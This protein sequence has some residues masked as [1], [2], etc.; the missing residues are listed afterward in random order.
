MRHACGEARRL[1]RSVNR[2]ELL[3]VG[4]VSVLGLSVADLLALREAQAAST[5]YSTILL[6][7]TGGP[8]QFDTFDPK[9]EAPAEV[10]G[11]FKAIP[12]NV[13]GIQFA[14]VFSRT[15]KYADRLAVLRSVYHGLD[16]HVLAQGWMTA[17]RLHDTVNYPPMGSVVARLAP[18]SLVVPPFVTLPRMALI[19]GFNETQHSQTAGDLG[20][21]YN[22]LIPDG[23][24][25]DAGF[26]VRD[27]ALPGGVDPA[28]F[29]RRT[30]LLSGVNRKP[31]AGAPQAGMEA[32]YEKAF[33]LIHS[34]KV[35]AA[36]SLEKEPAALRDAYGRNGFGQATLLARRLIEAG[37]RFVTVNWPSYYAWDQHGSIESGMK[38]TGGVLDMALSSLLE[39][40]ATRGLLE[41]T[42]VLVMGEFGRTPRINAGA[43]RDH[44]PQVMSVLMAGAR[45]RGGQVIGSST[46]DGYPDERPVHARDMVATAYRAIGINPEA[47]LPTVMGRP[48]KILPDAEPVQELLK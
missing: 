6:W 15:A 36:F 37:V 14:E 8:S 38:S 2:R 25:G 44:W 43:G 17:G 42:L 23:I 18:Q 19:A 12:T 41:R 29:D 46:N 31:G 4:C 11:P 35:H 16:H 22:P 33:D 7:L 1:A 40:L 5:D 30:R 3:T 13:N 10:R 27:V 47:E 32:I 34:E 39:D 28:R 48:I 9:P 20:P 24:P 21:A 26:A 45:I